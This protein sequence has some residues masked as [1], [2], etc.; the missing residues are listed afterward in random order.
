MAIPAD[1]PPYAHP[2]EQGRLGQD[3]EDMLSALGDL[4][5][6]V[7]TGGDEDEKQ[8]ARHMARLA[9]VQLSGLADRAEEVGTLCPAVEKELMRAESLVAALSER[10]LAWTLAGQERPFPGAD[11]SWQGV[12]PRMARSE[13]VQSV[14]RL[15]VSMGRRFPGDTAERWRE[16]AR[17]ASLDHG[18]PRR[19]VH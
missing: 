11:E 18:G 17:A 4:A 5:R 9:A 16:M 13:Y 15:L 7:G 14:M 3:V 2:F 8:R 12:L 1:P 10:A 6:R 19:M